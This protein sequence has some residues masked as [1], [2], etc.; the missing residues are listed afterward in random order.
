MERGVVKAKAEA[1]E[2]RVEIGGI[3][4]GSMRRRSVLGVGVASPR[5][6]NASLARAIDGVT[7]PVAEFSSSVRLV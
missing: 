1:N 7:C 5:R 2:R 3:R 6:G 4:P